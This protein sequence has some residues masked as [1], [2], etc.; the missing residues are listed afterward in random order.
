MIL[1]DVAEPILGFNFFTDYRLDLKWTKR[2]KCFLQDEADRVIPLK[3]D[4]FNENTVNLAVL[5][6][7]QYSQTKSAEAAKTAKPYVIPPDYKAIIDQFPKLLEVNFQKTPV[8]GIV[9][10]IETGSS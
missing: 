4:S 2:G 3:M 10:T 8:H 1:A 7:K 9:H 5:T 6:F